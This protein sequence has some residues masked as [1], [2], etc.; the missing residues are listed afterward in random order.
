MQ[1]RYVAQILQTTSNTPT[2]KIGLRYETEEEE[3]TESTKPNR[4]TKSTLLVQ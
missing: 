2:E 1:Y 3:F 4:R